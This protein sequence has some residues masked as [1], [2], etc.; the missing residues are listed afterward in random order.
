MKCIALIVLLSWILVRIKRPLFESVF[1]IILLT[2]ILIYLL[3]LILP[4]TALLNVIVLGVTTAALF[5]CSARRSQA[6]VQVAWKRE[7]LPVLVFCASFSVIHFLCLLWPDFI[8]MG[9]R[10]RDYAILASV[11][12]SPVDMQ[13][14]WMVGYKLN[15]YAYWYRLGHFF[16][17]LFGLKTWAVYHELQAFTF[18]LY[19]ACIFRLFRTHLKFSIWS[20]LFVALFISFGSNLTGIKFAFTPDQNWWGPS[21]V[22]TGAI[23]EFPAWSFLLGDLHPHYLNLPFI[24]FLI[25]VAGAF[26]GDIRTSAAKITFLIC[27]MAVSSI[28]L[29]NSNA[30]EMPIL[31]GLILTWIVA[32]LAAKAPKI[33]RLN[34]PPVFKDFLRPQVLLLGAFTVALCAS[35]IHAAYYITPGGHPWRFVTSEVGR[36]DLL[37]LLWHWGGAL[38]LITVAVIALMPKVVG[39][40][41]AIVLLGSALKYHE[42]WLFLGA[43]FCLN[44]VRAALVCRAA[45]KNGDEDLRELFVFE[46]LGIAALGFLIMPEVIFLDDPY[47]GEIDRMNTIFKVYSAN[48]VLLHISAFYLTAKAYRQWFNRTAAK[49]LLYSLQVATLLC[50][51]AFFIKTAT[52]RKMSA[53]SVQ[54]YQQGLSSIDREFP[55]AAAIIKKLSEKPRGTVLEAQG[56]PYS[57]TSHVSTLAEQP[58][59]LGWANHMG[60]LLRNYDDVKLREEIT[61][62]IYTDANCETKR[63]VA[64]ESGIKYV[65]VG[66]LEGRQYPE[67]KE[68][69]F[70]CM[71]VELS[72]GQYKVYKP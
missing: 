20:A 70:K 66:P 44:L 47:G 32:R 25:L 30:W 51:C 43:L 11:I 28:W 55:G 27:T 38:A 49:V 7:V 29:Y 18:A 59:Y 19:G 2:P 61:K 15:Y 36:T 4:T 40:V 62:K 39:K 68:D 50:F 34:E 42:A 45:E 35:L 64:L 41:V 16:A 53:F 58:A 63:R 71:L 9:E 69:A 48:W 60:L 65:V 72:E 6:E 5:F 21:R 37:E 31:A 26:W 17:S 52:I 56:N 33:F 13:E 57:Y 23:N 8:A 54:P 10:L 67:L 22:V 3:G 1:G 24:P 14:P 46:T 12:H